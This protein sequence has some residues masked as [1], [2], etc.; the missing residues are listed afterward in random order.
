MKRFCS[1]FIWLPLLSGMCTACPRAGTAP[2]TVV[3]VTQGDTSVFVQERWCPRQV[4]HGQVFGL[5]ADHVLAAEGSDH[6]LGKAP[7]RDQPVAAERRQNHAA[8]SQLPAQ[9]LLPALPG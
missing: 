6:R 5:D 8:T 1:K 2:A 4:V 9:T 3:A 7:G